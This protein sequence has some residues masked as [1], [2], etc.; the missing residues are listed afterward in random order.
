[1]RSSRYIIVLA[2][3]FLTILSLP[4]RGQDNGNSKVSRKTE[5]SKQ[6]VEKPK[7]NV[8]TRKPLRHALLLSAPCA[9]IT[10]DDVEAVL[11]RGDNDR[12]IATPHDPSWNSDNSQASCR[13]EVQYEHRI[14]PDLSYDNSVTLTIDF[15]NKYAQQGHLIVY[16]PP[17][18]ELQI[19]NGV[20]DEAL[21]QHDKTPRETNYGTA[22]KP[23]F[24]DFENRD[25]L[26]VRKGDLVLTFH[27]GS[28]VAGNTTSDKVIEI[29]RKTLPRVH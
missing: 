11:K 3:G 12:A 19:I 4:V 13:F 15:E 25:Y 18:N 28:I 1:M 8:L 10:R 6:V 21:Y 14:F 23:E 9:V 29:A 27:I 20:G 26:F 17:N 24:S 2:S 7:T 22:S 16:P 5:P